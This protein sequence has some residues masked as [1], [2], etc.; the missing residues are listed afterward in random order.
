MSAGSRI[1]LVVVIERLDLLR[2]QPLDVEGARETKCFSRSTACA[3]QISPPVQRRTES[4]GSRIA[5][6]PHS[7]QVSGK[8]KG[9]ASGRARAQV[10]VGDLGDHVARAVDLHPVADADVAPLAD[11]GA[12]GIAAGDVVLVVQ[13]GVR[14]QHAAHVTGRSRATGDSAPVRPTWMSMPSSRV[15]AVSAGNLCA[16]AQRGVVERKPSRACSARSS[17]L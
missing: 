3:G 16:M 13:R 5:G 11:R 8:A 6:E 2:A 17:T 1:Q 14:D 12:L 15:Q 10:H 7:G 9:C 4:P